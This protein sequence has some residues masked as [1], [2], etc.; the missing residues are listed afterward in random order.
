MIVIFHQQ[1]ATWHLLDDLVYTITNIKASH[2][3]LPFRMPCAECLVMFVWSDQAFRNSDKARL[4]QMLGP[5]PLIR[6]L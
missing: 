3:E 5:A 6:I 4:A 1:T 2:F